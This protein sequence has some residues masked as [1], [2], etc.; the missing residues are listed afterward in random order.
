MMSGTK[1]PLKNRN[2]QDSVFFF[3]SGAALIWYSLAKHY[4]GPPVAWKMS[5]Y[6]FPILV[7]VFLLLL[8]VSLFFDGL[9]QIRH[10]GEKKAGPVK[11]RSVLITIA[12]SAAYIVL[13]GWISF[14]P[15]TIIFLS[16]FIFFLGERRLW[17]IALAALVSALSLYGIFG[18]ALGVMLP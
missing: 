5:P 15:A 2:I 12:L 8:S 16:V 14:I 9:Y 1:K 6:L 3:C 17:L 7:S 10:G 4:G 13:M 11:S 18:M